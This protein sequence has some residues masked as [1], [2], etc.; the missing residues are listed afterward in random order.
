MVIILGGKFKC[1][2]FSLTADILGVGTV[3]LL[4]GVKMA[5]VVS[6]VFE[7]HGKVQGMIFRNFPD[8][9]HFAVISIYLAIFSLALA[10]LSAKNSLAPHVLLFILKFS[11][12]Q[13]EKISY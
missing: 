3:T 6:V 7:V 4:F 9:V 1:G 8:Y 12:A 11:S 13:R 5:K 2:S 10:I